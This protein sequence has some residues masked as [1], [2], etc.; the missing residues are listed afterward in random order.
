MSSSYDID[1]FL[2]T[3]STDPFAKFPNIGDTITGIIHEEPYMTNQFDSNGEVRVFD[4][5]NPMKMLII[6]LSTMN[7]NVLLPVKGSVIPESKSMR[8]AVTA[9]LREAKA[10]LEVGGKLTIVYIGDGE[11]PRPGFNAPKQYRAVYQPKAMVR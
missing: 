1:D 4:D 5:G 7:G 10:K 8:A 3:P 2:Y 9:A 6:P 11:P